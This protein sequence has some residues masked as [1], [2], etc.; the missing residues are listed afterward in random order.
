MA[1]ISTTETFTC[2]HC[3][4]DLRAVP[5]PLSRHEFCGACG[6]ALHACRQ[7]RWFDLRQ[8]CSESRADPPTDPAAA[9]F[10]EWFALGSGAGG[11]ASDARSSAA[12]SARARLEALFAPPPGD[13]DE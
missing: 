10:C 1:V 4:N 6:E 7:C 13:T 8:G 2:W 5:L 3:G 9:N 11:S 12:A